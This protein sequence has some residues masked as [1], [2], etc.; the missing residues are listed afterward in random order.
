MSVDGGRAVSGSQYKQVV[1][2][3][4][5]EQLAPERQVNEWQKLKHF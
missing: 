4:Q 5:L 2:P 3:G 1:L